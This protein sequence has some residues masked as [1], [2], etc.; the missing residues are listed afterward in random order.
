MSRTSWRVAGM[1]ALVLSACATSPSGP[2]GAGPPEHSL[3]PAPLRF[4]LDKSVWREQSVGSPTTPGMLAMR[5]FFRE[6]A[7]AGAQCADSIMLV[8]ETVRPETSTVQYSAEKRKAMPSHMVEQV[9]THVDGPLRLRNA[10]GYL[11]RGTQGCQPYMYMVHARGADVGYN[12]VIEVDPLDY[13]V[14][15]REVEAI[16]KSFWLP[17]P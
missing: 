12:I 14:I 5:L 15:H 3:D 1:A 10:V 9:F 8:A 13:A 7:A 2:R 17:P 4:D 11:V 16:L 6:K